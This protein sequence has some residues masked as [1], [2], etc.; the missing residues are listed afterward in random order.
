MC[1]AHSFKARS[2]CNRVTWSICYLKEVVA[3]CGKT[4][5]VRESVK[6]NLSYINRVVWT[7]NFYC[8]AAVAADCQCFKSETFR[9]D[10]FRHYAQTVWCYKLTVR[11]NLERAVACI[12]VA[13][14]IL[15]NSEKPFAFNSKVCWI[16]C[17]L[18]CALVKH[19]LCSCNLYTAAHLNTDWSY[20]VFCSRCTGSLYVLI[21]QIL[22]FN[23]L[24]LKTACIYVR[25]VVW[26]CI[27][28]S[29]LTVH[30]GCCCP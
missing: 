23:A 14:V 13:A 30:T 28:V 2:A 6:L 8:Y 26:N 19:A 25:Q 16:Q 12:S 18:Q 22:K 1:L 17:A 9:H 7:C 29:L 15:L 5:R 24:L 4:N 3:V 11:V 27:N 21:N 10:N 20:C